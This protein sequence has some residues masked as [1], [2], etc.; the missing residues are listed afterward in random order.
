MKSLVIVWLLGLLALGAIGVIYPPE[1]TNVY[2]TEYKTVVQ[3]VEVAG[4]PP[5]V[6]V[7]V[8]QRVAVQA[9]ALAVTVQSTRD[10]TEALEGRLQ[11]IEGDA[12]KATDVKALRVYVDEKDKALSGKMDHEASAR[13][14]VDILFAVLLGLATGFVIILAGGLYRHVKK[15]KGGSNAAS[16]GE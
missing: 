6:D 3:P 15:T 16:T 9:D 11:R 13:N 10:K 7:S 12:A 14:G 4:Q 1:D 2:P 5:T 8:V